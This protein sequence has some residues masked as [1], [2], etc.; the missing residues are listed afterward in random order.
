MANGIV[1]P[2]GGF[3]AGVKT[4]IQ[5]GQFQQ[6][7]DLEM[8]KLG[9]T[10]QQLDLKQRTSEQDSVLKMLQEKRAQAIEKR[11]VKKA[12][13][14]DIGFEQT[15]VG[16]IS[17]KV[18]SLWE[19]GVPQNKAVA[20]GLIEQNIEVLSK[21]NPN[22]LNILEAS[23]DDNDRLA[24]GNQLMAKAGAARSGSKEQTDFMKQA[25]AKYGQAGKAGAAQME[26]LQKTIG[27]GELGKAAKAAA[28]Q[29]LKKAKRL[30]DISTKAANLKQARGLGDFALALGLKAGANQVAVDTALKQLAKE[31]KDLGDLDLSASLLAMREGGVGTNFVW[32]PTT[33]SIVPKGQ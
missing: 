17:Q 30:S 28:D 33:R 16:L 23:D 25:F 10:K 22:F 31:A 26:E 15:Q 18:Q 19:T 27:K 9:L 20:R 13:Q 11:A 32:D 5:Q 14:E 29:S 8:A 1:D 24:E 6:T 4:L 12:G 21:H 2:F 3:K 7:A